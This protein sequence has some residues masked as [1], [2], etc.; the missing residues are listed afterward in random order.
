MWFE[1]AREGKT[2][3]EPPE[4][5]D[6]QEG[7]MTEDPPKKTKTKGKNALVGDN[8]ARETSEDI[9]PDEPVPAL[10]MSHLLP[11]K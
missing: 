4:V 9:A 1:L 6:D 10:F 8:L 2:R 7:Q 11:E 5:E 3:K